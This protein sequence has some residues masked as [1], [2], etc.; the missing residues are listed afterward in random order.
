MNKKTI[1]KRVEKKCKKGKWGS[2]EKKY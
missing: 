1:L 2:G